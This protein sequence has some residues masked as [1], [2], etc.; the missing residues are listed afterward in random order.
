MHTATYTKRHTLEEPP[1]GSLVLCSHCTPLF[2]SNLIWIISSTAE[3][4]QRDFSWFYMMSLWTNK[5]HTKLSFRLCVAFMI[6]NLSVYLCGQKRYVDSPSVI[7]CIMDWCKLYITLS[8]PQCIV[9]LSGL[10][11][12]TISIT[13]AI[14][15]TVGTSTSDQAAKLGSKQRW[16]S[17]RCEWCFRQMHWQWQHY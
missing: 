14:R 1:E 5:K 4:V 15:S 2:N 7:W 16:S 9:L 13:V 12:H 6:I 10:I 17:W 8:I 11:W 3:L